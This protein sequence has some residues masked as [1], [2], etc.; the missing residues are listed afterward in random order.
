[1][2]KIL[3]FFGQ[4]TDP[5][6]PGNIECYNAEFSNHREAI[7]GCWTH[8]QTACTDSRQWGEDYAGTTSSSQSQHSKAI[9][10]LA[11]VSQV[12]GG[13]QVQL[14]PTHMPLRCMSKSRRH[15]ADEL[16]YQQ[17]RG[18]HRHHPIR[19][20]PQQNPWQKKQHIWMMLL[21]GNSL[22]PHPIKD[23][24]SPHGKTIDGT[25]NALPGG[26]SICATD[27]YYH[28]KVGATYLNELKRIMLTTATQDKVQQ[29]CQ[30]K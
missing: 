19:N 25:I 15:L 20:I 4:C 30:V 14:Y 18:Y 2:L 11:L 16:E 13:E 28:S 10:C 1:M 9:A 22:S 27:A 6:K 17:G 7:L 23:A 26:A 21:S 8:W 5:L 24:L 29:H 12:S 3:S